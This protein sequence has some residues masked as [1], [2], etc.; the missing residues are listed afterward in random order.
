MFKM[1]VYIYIN[2]YDVLYLKQMPNVC[3]VAKS[4]RM[5]DPSNPS[6][7]Q[8]SQNL[9]ALQLGCRQA[10]LRLPTPCQYLGERAVAS[11]QRTRLVSYKTTPQRVGTLFGAGVKGN[12]R[13]AMLG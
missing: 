4:I 8:F 12:Q 10:V 13:E 11:T 2:T 3:A 7:A 9:P 5:A 6:H 1:C